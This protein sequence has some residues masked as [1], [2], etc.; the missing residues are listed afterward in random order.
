M[1]FFRFFLA[2]FELS[3]FLCWW[4]SQLMNLNKNVLFSNN[5][6]L[7]FICVHFIMIP[8]AFC[9]RNCTAW[10]LRIILKSILSFF[11]SFFLFNFLIHWMGYYLILL[12]L[13][14]C[15]FVLQHVISLVLMLYIVC[16]WDRNLGSE[17]GTMCHQ[18]TQ[19]R[20]LWHLKR[21]INFIC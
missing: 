6:L 10:K 9:V 12:V 15:S 11:F 1:W 18:L 16:S 19:I 13:P 2:E 5:L 3:N 7:W 21:K 8:C 4:E 17:C 14:K 20:I